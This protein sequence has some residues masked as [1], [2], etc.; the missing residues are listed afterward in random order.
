MVMEGKKVSGGIAIGPVV[1][2]KKTDH[3]V[4]H[5]QVT[6][7]TAE[8]ARFQL[9]K[10]EAKRQLAGL[11]EKAQKEAGEENAAIFQAHQMLL[12]D[13]EYVHAI[14]DLIRSQQINAEYAVACAGEQFADMF[15]IMEDDYMRQRAADMKDI[16][17][18]VVEILQGNGNDR[19]SLK[20][21]VI[22]L[23]DDLSPS[24][25]IRLDK[26]KILAFVTRYGSANSHTAILARGMNIPALVGVDFVADLDGKTAIVDGY[27]GKLILDPDGEMLAAYEKKKQ[28]DEENRKLLLELKGKDNVTLNGQRVELYANIGG[29]DDVDLAL[30]N[31]AGGIGL[32]RSEFLYMGAA[33]YPDEETQFQAYRTV[34]QRMAGKKVVIRTM[35]IGADKQA[36]YFHLDQEAN[37]AMG[38]R[39]I[40]ICLDRPD[41]F[42]TQ[43]R[44]ICRA[45]AYGNVAIMFPMII[46][47]E[48]VRR[49]KFILQEVKEELSAAGISYGEPEL[50]IMIETPA[51]VMMSEELGGEV[52]FFSV[53]TNDLTQYTLAM[54]R[55]NEKL[56]SICDTH[57]PAILKM[58]Q[59]VVENGHKNGC[60]VGICGELAADTTMTETL[61]KM[62]Y[63]EL[64][65]SPSMI[66]K[67]RQKIRS[68]DITE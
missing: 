55:Q 67:L 16:S 68:L 19:I 28:Q 46:S 3:K 30:E 18:L 1:W 27:E 43:L 14:T 53:G 21:P 42:K 25:T 57:H 38:Y 33:D 6:D 54:D 61:L 56:A 24:E 50:G 13:E 34:A 15:S 32:F 39:A 29:V 5:R 52:D 35:D 63:D 37:P 4:A 7:T 9:A 51:A 2:Y 11:Q 41:I 8:V 64:S 47:V 65:V 36:D 48:E 45:A 12:E 22:L 62:G 31:D 26:T 66:L 23:A 60:W 44:A 17:N 58:L 40:R 59:M 20:E 49:I 10:D